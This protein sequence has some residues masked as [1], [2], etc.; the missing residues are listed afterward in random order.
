MGGYGIY[1]AQGTEIFLGL[2]WRLSF[3]GCLYYYLSRDNEKL[4][5]R[6]RLWFLLAAVILILVPEGLLAVTASNALYI[7]LLT[8][9]VCLTG[10]LI[11]G[12][13]GVRILR[14]A[15]YCLAL[16]AYDSLAVLLL[17]AVLN[18][19]FQ[20][21]SL[22]LESWNVWLGLQYAVKAA[23]EWALSFFF[24]RAFR[25]GEGVNLTGR[26]YL[27]LS[28]LPVVSLVYLLSL[29]ACSD[30]FILR[31]GFWLLLLNLV[32][33]LGMNGFVIW[34]FRDQQRRRAEEL[35]LELYR[36]QELLRMRQYQELEES[37]QASRKVIHDVKNHMQIL[38]R[39]YHSGEIGDADRYL[40]DMNGM[41]RSL[42]RVVYTDQ[43]ML[44]IILNE[45]LNVEELKG[46]RLQ[47]QV[48]EIHLDFMRNVD[49]TTI[50]T[51]LLDNGKE[52]LR[53][54][55]GEKYLR[56]TVE[57]VRDFLLIDMENTWNP[58]GEKTGHQGLGLKNVENALK[59]YHGTLRTEQRENIFH[60]NILI[61]L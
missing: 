55:E 15:V 8:V 47:I 50:F 45:K 34:L 57:E 11:F 9:L 30:I 21:I 44:N 5:V 17:Q 49:I 13:R 18:G 23:G 22:Y 40:R 41:L 51:N 42:D 52:A 14:T 26:Q 36:Q 39:L 2:L 4:S 37:Y 25:R 12:H 61:P 38:A 35:E 27:V 3:L 24:G 20:T 59:T 16:M 56:L 32:L 53:Q 28:F 10:F 54:V 1:P 29:L 31:Y 43:K 19:N 60:V 46:V 6:R 48:G 7:G 58:R 33:I